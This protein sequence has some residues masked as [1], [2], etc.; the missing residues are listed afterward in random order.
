[1]TR[2]FARF[3]TLALVA[4]LFFGTLMPGSW[5]EAAA[6]PL[7]GVV[8]ISVLAHV[9]LFAAIC[10]MLPLARFW[11]VE[12]WHLL[13]AGLALALL[14]EGLQHFAV[15]RHPELAGLGQDMLGAFIGW[16]LQRALALP[17]AAPI[18]AR[19]I[20]RSRY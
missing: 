10:F 3:L 1:M 4:L 16:G 20:R 14:T 11:R 13:A 7:Y 18:R 5:K 19:L 9:A 8:D 12:L 15:N 2:S 6:Q 17:S